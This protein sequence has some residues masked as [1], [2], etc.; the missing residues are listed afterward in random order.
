[1]SIHNFTLVKSLELEIQP[2]MTA[3]TGETGAGKSVL[4]EAIGLTLG[5]RADADRIRAGEQRADISAQFDVSQRP[6]VQQWLNDNDLS[7]DNEYADKECL[8]RR[9][10]TQEGRSRAYINGQPVTASQLKALGSQLIDLHSQHAH[11]GLL[12]KETHV[13]LLDEFG[14]HTALAHSV[15]KTWATWK[16]LNSKCKIIDQTQAENQERLTLL[17]EQLH[18]LEL[19]NLQENELEALEEEQKRLT[20]IEST[21]HSSYQ[22]ANLCAGEDH[23]IS[24]ALHNAL[25]ILSNIPYK[26]THLSEAESLLL[27][28]QIQVQEAHQEIERHINFC[29]LSPE[30]LDFVEERLSTI[31]ECARKHRVQPH[32][33][34]QLTQE[35]AQEATQLRDSDVNLESLTKKTQLCYEE[36]TLQASKLSKKREAAQK[37]LSKSVN[38]LLKEMNMM[39]AQFEI[40]L[41]HQDTPGKEGL[42][43]IEFLVSTNP[44]AAARPLA[45]VAS[46]GELSRISLAIQVVTANAV[47]VPTIIFDEV[48][49]GI[50]G[51]TAHVV[52]HLLRRL[53]DRTQVLCVTHLGQVAAKAHHHLRVSKHQVRQSTTSTLESLQGDTKVTEIAR[54]LSGNETEQSLAHARE[55]LELA[56]YQ[57]RPN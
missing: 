10:I 14:Q 2:G 25:H 38:Q 32:Q 6:A 28:A 36:L 23:S 48:D 4:L 27:N 41:N 52:G 34:D 47:Q 11:Q 24:G 5:D 21:L 20:T 17:E 49:V 29:D 19:L 9:I 42:E 44:G 54:M 13:T 37:H 51:A 55:M 35:L 46:G 16:D 33:L 1:M 56:E 3:V 50:G 22:L 18:E 26:D 57:S 31:Y 12:R 15:A 39:N 8:V 53:G 40:T 43:E 45:K 30:R 7:V